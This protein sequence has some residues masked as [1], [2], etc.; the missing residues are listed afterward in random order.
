LLSSY[1]A[2]VFF[3]PI[4]LMAIPSPQVA[5]NGHEWQ[6]VDNREDKKKNKQVYNNFLFERKERRL[7]S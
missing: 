1:E 4:L 3:L 7:M 5:I 6:E 2:E